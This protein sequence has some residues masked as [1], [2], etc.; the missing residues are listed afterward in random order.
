MIAEFSTPS[1]DRFFE[2]YEVGAT[3]VCGSF[4]LTEEEIIAFAC[5]YDPQA[6][7]TDRRLAAEGPFGGLIA[8]GWH[9]IGRAMRLLVDEFLP[10]NGL[11]APGID[12]LRWP[13][14]VLPNDTL[15]VQVTVRSARRSRGKP[16]RGLLHTLLEVLNQHNEVVLSMKP[17]NLVRV[18]H[19][20]IP[21]AADC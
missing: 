6:M 19:P 5:L 13:R 7:H 3:Y 4:T 20:E 1:T 21:P 9:T 16:D 14:P 12:E 8:S 17:M 2:D 15:T 10:H 11:A 18:R